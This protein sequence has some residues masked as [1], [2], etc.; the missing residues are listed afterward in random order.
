MSPDL[1]T[2]KEAFSP[3]G[4]DADATAHKQSPPAAPPGTT[5]TS[6]SGRER[7]TTRSWTRA[8][9]RPDFYA[10]FVELRPPPNFAEEEEEE[11]SRDKTRTVEVSQ[12]RTFGSSGRGNR[13]SI[14]DKKK[15]KRARNEKRSRQTFGNVDGV[16]DKE[17]TYKCFRPDQTYLLPCWHTPG[18]F[19]T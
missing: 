19:Q 14:R 3:P 5:T 4:A 8:E 15:K 6:T 12:G 13:Y 7:R 9:F 10:R 11:T 17:L 16:M 2:T 18:A 1:V